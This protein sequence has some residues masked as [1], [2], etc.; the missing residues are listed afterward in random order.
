MLIT[1][2]YYR[3]K[4]VQA[5]DSLTGSDRFELNIERDSSL[6]RGVVFIFVVHDAR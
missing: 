2:P 4:R 6:C 3:Y 1:V 5:D